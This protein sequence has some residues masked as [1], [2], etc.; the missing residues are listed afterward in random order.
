MKE[1]FPTVKKIKFEGPDSKYPLAFKHYNPKEKVLGKSMADH[2]RFAVSYWHT[3]KGTGGDPF[4]PGTYIR[5][6]NN[7]ADEMEAAEMTMHAAFEFFTKLGVPSR[8]AATAYG[9]GHNLV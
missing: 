3:F 9:Y 1:F 5:E 4:G 7:A 2:F 6:Y 8:S